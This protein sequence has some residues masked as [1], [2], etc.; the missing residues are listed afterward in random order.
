[1][2]VYNL[3]PA[4]SPKVYDIEEDKEGRL[5]ISTH[6]HFLYKTPSS[7]QFIPIPYKGRLSVDVRNM[8]KAE[9]ACY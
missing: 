3:P 5:F 2:E 9:M 8:I 6:D 7:S 4:P 1:M